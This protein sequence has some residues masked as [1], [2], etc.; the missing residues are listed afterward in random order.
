MVKKILS[1]I[2]AGLIAGGVIGAYTFPVEKEVVLEKVINVTKEVPVT[3]TEYV[4]VEK[5]IEVIKEVNVTKEVFVDNGKLDEVLE[6]IY[7]NKGKVQYLTEDLDDDEVALIA[8]RII[9]INEVKKLAVDV[10]KD[11]LFDELDN[12]EL[13]TVKFDDKEMERLRVD[14]DED[15]IVIE[16]VDFDDK[17]ADV[18]VTGTFEQDDVKYK[19]EALVEFKDNEFDEI[20]NIEVEEN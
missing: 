7:D 6:H 3:V 11:E 19:F 18:L 16:E 15:E 20:K 17:D 4:E 1:G 9:F 13:G 2:A 8:D 5:P 12:E 10:V 14:D